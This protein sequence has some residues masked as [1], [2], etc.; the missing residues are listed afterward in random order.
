MQIA[1]IGTSYKFSPIKVLEQASL[2]Q[3]GLAQLYSRLREETEVRGAVLLSTCNRCELYF[4][5]EGSLDE[6]VGKVHAIFATVLAVPVSFFQDHFRVLADQDLVQHLFEVAS[7]SDSMVLGDNEI[8]GQLKSAYQTAVDAQVT[9]SMLNK[10]FQTA[11]AVGKRV[12]HETGM[13]K[14]AYSVSSIGVDGMLEVFGDRR[15]LSILVVGAGRV[16]TGTIKKLVALGFEDLTLTNRSEVRSTMLQR[17]YNLRVM[18]FSDWMQRLSEVDI[19]FLT[20]SS[21]TPLITP[22]ILAQLS[23]RPQMLVDLGM[24]RNVDPRVKGSGIDLLALD[25]IHDVA[26]RNLEAR[27]GELHRVGVIVAEEITKLRKWLQFPV[28]LAQ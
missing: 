2:N 26:N 25:T 3:E 12:R 22:E 13:S 23:S 19:V 27:K 20:T 9:T 10:L 6:V 15:D 17:L 11:I 16:G 14:G 5:Y 24:P 1:K 8:L 7:G 28:L 18:P 4:G 21:E